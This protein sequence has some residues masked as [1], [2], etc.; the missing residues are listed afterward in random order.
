MYIH[1]YGESEGW[2]E[3]DGDGKDAVYTHTPELRYTH[4]HTHTQVDVGGFIRAMLTGVLG[5]GLCGE[6]PIK[7]KEENGIGGGGET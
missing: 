7:E 3:P 1:V 6:E 2:L 4:T 5:E